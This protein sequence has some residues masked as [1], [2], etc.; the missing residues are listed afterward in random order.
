MLC[1]TPP[2]GIFVSHPFPFFMCMCQESG[3]ERGREGKGRQAGIEPYQFYMFD[4]GREQPE[5]GFLSLLL[6]PG[7][8]HSFFLRRRWW[9]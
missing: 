8:A 6:T 7:W 9:W 3:G 1:C 4:Q 5:D 2:F